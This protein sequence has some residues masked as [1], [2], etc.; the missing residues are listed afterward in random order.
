MKSPQTFEEISKEIE[1]HPG[2]GLFQWKIKGRKRKFNIL[3]AGS[4]H[5]NGYRI[6]GIY[7]KK[8]RAHRLAWLL[9]TG[10]WP[11]NDI[12]HIDGDPSNNRI[13]N[14]RQAAKSENLWNCKIQ[15]NNTSGVKGVHW[16]SRRGKWVA[17][18]KINGKI[19]HLGRFT[20]IKDA[21]ACIINARELNHGAFC[22]HG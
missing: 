19:K 14:L 11:I 21:D 10:V 8:H 4:L 20:D 17:Q 7:G 9:S 1:Y 5:L 15:S 6:I 18:I 22:N 3:F 2:F 13:R 12:D 16:D